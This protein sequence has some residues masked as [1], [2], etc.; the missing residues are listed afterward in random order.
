[1]KLVQQSME[2]TLTDWPT[3]WGQPSNLLNGSV[4]SLR[5]KLL[6]I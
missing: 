4:S 2:G 1:M 5:T 6:W 3:D